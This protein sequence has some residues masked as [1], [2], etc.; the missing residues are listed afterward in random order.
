M[1]RMS[2]TDKEKYG[3]NVHNFIVEKALPC[4]NWEELFIFFLYYLIHLFFSSLWWKI[5]TGSFII[6]RRKRWE[7]GDDDILF[8]NYFKWNGLNGNKYIIQ[9]VS[10]NRYTRGFLILFPYCFSSGMPL[11]YM[12]DFVTILKLWRR[13]S[14]TIFHLFSPYHNSR[15]IK[16]KKFFSFW[17]LYHLAHV[18]KQQ[19]WT[20]VHSKNSLPCSCPAGNW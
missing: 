3:S 15:E 2:I 14:Y 6:K 7:K 12:D 11:F 5:S 8:I 17:I 16:Q 4:C 13:N 10:L 19:I 18:C 9:E 20:S 1:D